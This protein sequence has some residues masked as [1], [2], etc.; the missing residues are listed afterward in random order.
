MAQP[1][2]R[3]GQGVAKPPLKELGP[4]P[5]TERPIVVKDG[6]FGPYVTD[7][8]TNA[9]LRKGDDVEELTMERALELLADRR[10]RGPVK[11][12]SKA[13]KVLL[14][15]GGSMAFVLVAVSA[16]GYLY[17]QHLNHNIQS[18]DDDGASTGGFQKDKAINILLIGTDKRTGKGNGNYG[19]KGSVGHAD[20]NI[21]LHVSKD[22]SNATALSIPAISEGRLPALKKPIRP[23]TASSA[24]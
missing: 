7:G 13:K 5:D 20:T 23:P 14:W 2:R 18:V 10:A 6:R 12:K 1:K 4:D 22:R 15:T 3:R 24:P 17:I 16:A 21:L 9:S 8:E 19:D 11:K